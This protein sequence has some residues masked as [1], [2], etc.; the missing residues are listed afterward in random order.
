MRMHP[1][2]EALHETMSHCAR[3]YGVHRT[4]Q[5]GSS[6]TRHQPCNNQPALWVHHFGGYSK[7]RYKKLAPY[8]ESHATRVQWICPRAENSTCY[9]KATNNNNKNTFIPHSTIQNQSSQHIKGRRMPRLTVRKQIHV[10]V[11]AQAMVL[12]IAAIPVCMLT[13][14][15]LDHRHQLICSRCAPVVTFVSV[16]KPS[17]RQ[18]PV[19]RSPSSVTP[20][21][22]PF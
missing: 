3:L 18:S 7:T 8:S 4:R 14:D 13:S 5:D 20:Q 22:V 15:S 19:Y 10:Q 1:K 6:I 9:I 17:K 11:H 2:Y 16:L 21:L 12:V